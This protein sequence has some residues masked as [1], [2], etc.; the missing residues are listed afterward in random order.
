MVMSE[1]G[2]AFARRIFANISLI[3]DIC[4]SHFNLELWYFKYG[5][6]ALVKCE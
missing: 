6:K 5:E 1:N 4:H 2:V 3:L